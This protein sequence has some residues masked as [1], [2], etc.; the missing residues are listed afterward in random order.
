MQLS[1][2]ESWLVPC[3]ATGDCRRECQNHRLRI[4]YSVPTVQG[5][6]LQSARHWEEPRLICASKD[7]EFSTAVLTPRLLRFPHPGLESN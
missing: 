3:G 2:T 5:C 7:A 4:Q 1:S 6:I